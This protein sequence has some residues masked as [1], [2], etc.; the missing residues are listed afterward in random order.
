MRFR[1]HDIV[2]IGDIEKA[3]LQIEVHEADRDYLRFLWLNDEGELITYRF[4]RVPFGLTSS[5]FLLNATL[6][7]HMENRCLKE[8]N[9]ELLA[10]LSKAHYVDDWILGA[11]TPAEVLLIKKW[12]VEFLEVIGMKLHKFN[13][14]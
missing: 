4:A 1:T 12:L 6:R 8:G 13:S 9:P 7:H 14:N 10:I 11:K 5:S 2:L 3:F